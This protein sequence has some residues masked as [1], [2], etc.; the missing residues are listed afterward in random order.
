MHPKIQTHFDQLEG[1]RRNFLEQIA[2]FSEAEQRFKPN[3]ES[4]CALEVIEHI[5]TVESNLSE[6]FL[7]GATLEPVSLPSQIKGWVLVAAVHTPF[8]VKTPSPNA[9]PRQIPNFA[10]VT[11][12]WQE[13]RHRIKT[14]LEPLPPHALS[15]AAINHPL[16]KPM[17]L[18]QALAFFRGH[19]KHHQF[20]L[21]RIR[22]DLRA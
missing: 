3:P 21:E 13:Q 17:T 14:Y 12:R 6:H 19:L 22:R 7:S 8:K 18:A 20:Q 10:E 11:N 2:T 5:V 16:V 1:Q 4:W 15:R 9:I